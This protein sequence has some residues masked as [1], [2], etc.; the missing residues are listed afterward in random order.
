MRQQTLADSS[1]EK[2][3]KKTRKEQF[4]DEMEQVIAWTDL[5]E[6]IE[7]VLPKT[8]WEPD[9]ELSAL[10]VCCGSTFSSIGLSYLIL[11]LKK[12]CMTHVP[13]VDFVGIDL[14]R[15]PVPD[16]TTICKFRHLLEKYNLGDE[17]F[18][19][20]NIYLEENG[21]K[22]SRGTI[23]DATIINAP[24]STKTRIRNETRRCTRPARVTSGILG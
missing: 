7:P 21:M 24:S 1:F 23:V 3:R 15:E 12:P 19:I 11:V 10:S 8:R 4:L 18:Q 2:F 9:G 6:A 16:E 14:G 17:M 13:C 20:V 5:T 22:V